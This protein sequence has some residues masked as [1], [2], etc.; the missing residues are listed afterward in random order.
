MKQ[1]RALT[2][3]LA[4]TA[5]AAV[6]A[7]DNWSSQGNGCVPSN[8]TIKSNLHAT[9]ASS[10]KFASGKTG[11][12]TLFCTMARF[13]S[14]TVNYTADLTYQDSTGTGTGAY[15][16]AE[17]YKMPQGSAT[18]QLLGTVNSNTSS[19]TGLNNLSSPQ[20]AES[21][22]FEANVYWAKI[23]LKR[24][25]TNQNVIFHALVLNGANI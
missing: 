10:V 19:D 11:T 15:V 24:T 1:L 18:S 25:N 4:L 13:N 23:V 2:F 6:Q 20:F 12:I 16:R 9:T 14:G 22:D 21:F 3:I 17:I 8:G 5:P 7:Q